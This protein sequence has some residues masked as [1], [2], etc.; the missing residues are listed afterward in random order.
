[1]KFLLSVALLA[2]AFV[3]ADKPAA[4]PVTNNPEDKP[5][6]DQPAEKKADKELM[7]G[8]W[9]FS[10]FEFDGI[11]FTGADLK[12]SIV[13]QVRDLR[14]TVKEDGV[15][16][17]TAALLPG[18]TLKLALDPAEKPPTF[19]L[20]VVKGGKDVEE[21]IML[22]YELRGDTLRLCWGGSSREQRPKSFTSSGGQYVLT[23]KR[24]EKQPEK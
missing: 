7:Q 10:A 13:A 23:F 15:S 24:E 3:A 1:M 16:S 8:I 22:L 18:Q 11:V 19:D 21:K 14:V 9:V 17:S 6:A 2:G 4:K 20:Q 12:S 5:V